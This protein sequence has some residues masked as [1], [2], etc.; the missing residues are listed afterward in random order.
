MVDF[1]EIKFLSPSVSFFFARLGDFLESSS[2]HHPTMGLFVPKDYAF[3]PV[4]TGL[5]HH[6]VMNLLR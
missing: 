5:G 6:L 1:F 4:L 2:G 3:R